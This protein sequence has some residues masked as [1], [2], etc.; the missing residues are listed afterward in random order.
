MVT[1]PVR[2]LHVLASALVL[3][4]TLL[5][6]AGISWLHHSGSTVLA[7]ANA[8]P[9]AVLPAG[10]GGMPR[11]GAGYFTVTAKPGQTVHEYALILNRTRARPLV[12]VAPVDA[13]RSTS[14]LTYGLPGDARRGVGSWLHLSSDAFRVPPAGR[15]LVNLSLHVPAQIP[16]GTYA[17]ALSVTLPDGSTV[18]RASASIRVQVRLAVAVIVHVRR[19]GR[20]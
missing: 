14:G 7:A 16:L 10:P 13:Y 20:S 5:G 2:R 18:N 4:A 11:A 9:I 17:G 6:A 12:A 1:P 15:R 3:A 8:V 19:E